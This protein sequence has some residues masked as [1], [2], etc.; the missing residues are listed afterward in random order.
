MRYS[1]ML[2]PKEVVRNQRKQINHYS[3]FKCQILTTAQQ[4]YN[5]KRHPT[6]KLSH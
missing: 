3:V 5:R 6:C 2:P 4:W 1:S